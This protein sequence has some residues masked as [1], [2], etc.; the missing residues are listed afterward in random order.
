METAHITY[1]GNLRT[2]STHLQSGKV[3]ITDA[4]KD[5]EGNGEAFTPTDLVSSALASCML[6]IMG[7][8][9][10]RHNI[11]IEGTLVKV[12]KVMVA[13]PRRIG[14]IQVEINFNKNLSMDQKSKLEAAALACP[15]AKSLHPDI[16]QVVTFCYPE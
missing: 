15:V 2:T 6:T 8:I 16:R 14:E 4:P 5:N 7:I 10:K 9:A 11:Q 12:T 3:I 13:E 1:L